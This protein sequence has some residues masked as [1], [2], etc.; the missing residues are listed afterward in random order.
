MATSAKPLRVGLDLAKEVFQVH[1]VDSDGAVLEARQLKRDRLMPWCA[2]LP[3][4]SVVAMETCSAAHFWGRQLGDL[5]VEVRLIAPAFVKPFRMSGPGSKNDAADASAIC[6]AANS[7]RM[8]FVPVKSVEQQTWS[9]IH[10]LRQGYMKERTAT[11][12]RIRGLL[13]EFGL[14]FPK[15]PEKL[16]AALPEVL[17][18]RTNEL[19]TLGRTALRRA[20][21]HVTALDRQIAW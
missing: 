19:T 6:E 15:S 3:G 12:S 21:A 4:D 2:R 20:A 10:R 18:D 17:G 11:I 5:G 8:R 1:V 13:A 16:F 7:Q 14:V 9:S